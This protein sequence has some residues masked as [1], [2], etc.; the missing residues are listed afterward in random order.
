MTGIFRARWTEAIHEEWK[1]NLLA[2]RTDLTRAKLDR[3]SNLM[4]R[5]VP[6]CL[7]TD[8]ESLV[9][10]LQLPDA[11]DRHVL[12]AAIRGGA[13]VIVT[14]NLKDFPIDTLNQFDLEALHPDEFI[15]DLFDLD[16]A[17]VIK[18]A[19]NHRRS[20]NNPAFNAETYLSLLARQGLAQTAHSLRPYQSFL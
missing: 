1:R 13:S 7:I 17:A 11:D 4:N 14:F 2:R 12:A 16:Q 6:D 19:S 9:E 5:A 10:S 15:D 8:F 20:L 18:A 3:T